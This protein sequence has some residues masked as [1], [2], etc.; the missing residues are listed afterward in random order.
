MSLKSP[1]LPKTKARCGACNGKG[2]IVCRTCQGGLTR[3]DWKGK[4]H[5]C[6]G[7]GGTGEQACIVCGQM[8]VRDW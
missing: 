6:P 8:G 1:R 5:K 4:V 2:V 7:C 3:T